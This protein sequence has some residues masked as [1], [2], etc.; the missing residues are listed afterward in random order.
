M[1]TEREIDR[2]ETGIRIVLSVLFMLILRLVEFVLGAI[3]IFQ[4]IFALITKRP[5]GE[6]VTRF[7]NRIIAYFMQLL[8]YLTYQDDQRP[9]PFTDFPEDSDEAVP[10]GKANGHASTTLREPDEIIRPS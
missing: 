9:F 4:L 10:T 2:K 5:P 6:R 7:A 3:V 1:E 8:R